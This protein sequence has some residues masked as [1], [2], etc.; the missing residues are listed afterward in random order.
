MKYKLLNCYCHS[1]FTITT[2]LKFQQRKN[3][4][5]FIYVQNTL[6]VHLES[7]YSFSITSLVFYVC[8]LAPLFSFLCAS[9]C[10]ILYPCVWLAAPVALTDPQSQVRW[11]LS[12]QFLTPDLDSLIACLLSAGPFLSVLPSLYYPDYTQSVSMCLCLACHLFVI[13]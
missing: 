9:F 4:M 6:S 13:M 1:T 3:T 7:V 10:L 12:M 5:L 2:L 11:F 8:F